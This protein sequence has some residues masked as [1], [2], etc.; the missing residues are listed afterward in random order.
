MSG[1]WVTTVPEGAEAGFLGELQGGELAT[2]IDAGDI[3]F[4]LVAPDRTTTTTSASVEA[5]GFAGMY[6]T[7]FASAFLITHGPGVYRVAIVIDS[8]SPKL[9][10]T[11]YIQI[12]VHQRDIDEMYDL[13]QA[14]LGSVV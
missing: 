8:G 2:G 3:T 4:T 14:I 12:R 7:L 11:K 1:G 13:G 6:V 9:K 5:P 10:T